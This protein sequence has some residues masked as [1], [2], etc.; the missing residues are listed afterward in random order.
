MFILGI[1]AF[2]LYAAYHREDNKD[3]KHHFKV[4]NE[5]A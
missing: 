4:D 3:R 1:A 5:H 2:G